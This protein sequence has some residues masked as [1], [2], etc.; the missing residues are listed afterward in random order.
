MFIARWLA[1]TCVVL[2]GTSPVLLGAQSSADASV[3]PVHVPPVGLWVS[4]EGGNGHFAYTSIRQGTFIGKVNLSVGPAMLTFRGSDAGPFI[5]GGQGVRDN[6]LLGGVRTGWRHLFGSASLG[7]ANANHYVQCD[8]CGKDQVSPPVGV[9]V[10]DVTAH[11][12]FFV[13][14]AAASFSGVVGPTPV[15]Y[16]VVTVGFEAGWFGR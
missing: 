14:G 15:R 8:G 3:A 4:L 11:A 2:G 1:L 16:S 5:G 12:N 9:M 10:Y 13:V 6:G 7:F